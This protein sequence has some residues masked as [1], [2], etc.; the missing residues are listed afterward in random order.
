MERLIL[1]LVLVS[2]LTVNANKQLL[3]NSCI[4]CHD[5]DLQEGKFRIE[6]LAKESF[7]RDNILHW[8]K[9]YSQ[10]E[11]NFMPPKKSKISSED[12][13]KLLNYL[14]GEIR[15]FY[16]NKPQE[17]SKQRRLN[18]SEFINSLK[19]LVGLKRDMI[20]FSKRIPNESDMGFYFKSPMEA[21]LSPEIMNTYHQV[22]DHV[23]EYILTQ[24]TE[25]PERKTY[26]LAYK[27]SN[28]PSPHTCFGVAGR[29]VDPSYYPNGKAK[30]DDKPYSTGVAIIKRTPATRDGNR[31]FRWR[32]PTDGLYR[33][34]VGMWAFKNKKGSTELS[35]HGHTVPVEIRSGRRFIK[36][37]DIDNKRREY[38]FETFLNKFETLTLDP[39]FIKSYRNLPFG[40]GLGGHLQQNE[41]KG[42][43]WLKAVEKW[44]GEGIVFENLSVDGPIFKTKRLTYITYLFGAHR[45]V[46]ES[47]RE[48]STWR[49]RPE[50]FNH[51]FEKELSEKDI[52]TLIDRFAFRAYRGNYKQSEIGDFIAFYHSKYEENKHQLKALT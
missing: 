5:E 28:I 19:D 42:L 35:S 24:P 41:K 13:E 52:R 27:E 10:I 26:T 25:L 39:T 15:G 23:F 22:I 33:F 16:Q 44:S 30:Y 12:R 8:E 49:N 1:L 34:K 7:S 50:Y 2:T 45:L 46:C 21:S 48:G 47:K 51:R 11:H 4:D 32:A 14:S 38:V 36:L 43:P 29:E 17:V 37:I 40:K 31:R 9:V 18:K 6:M 3:L 20:L